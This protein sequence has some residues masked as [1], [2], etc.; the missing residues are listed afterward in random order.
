MEDFQYRR[1]TNEDLSIQTRCQL[2]GLVRNDKRGSEIVQTNKQT[3]R[4]VVFSHFHR[5]LVA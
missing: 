1:K 4:M 5:L 2:Q 3:N